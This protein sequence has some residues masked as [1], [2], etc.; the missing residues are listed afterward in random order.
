MQYAYRN[1][2]Y[3]QRGDIV[4]ATLTR[5]ANVRLLDSVNYARYR[6]GEK[7]TF[8]GHTAKKT[9]F[10]IEVPRAGNWYAVADMNGLRGATRASF[11]LIRRA[12]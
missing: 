3:C 1:L 7:C 6:R 5:G 11:R 9:P 8:Y 4:E 2:G 12:A 10:L